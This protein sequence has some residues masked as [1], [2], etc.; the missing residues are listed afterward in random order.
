MLSLEL[1]CLLSNKLGYKQDGQHTGLVPLFVACHCKEVS[2]M[3]SH[4]LELNTMKAGTFFLILKKPT[5]FSLHLG[6]HNN[7]I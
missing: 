6:L 1:R 5:V 4:P 3:M 7:G 2:V